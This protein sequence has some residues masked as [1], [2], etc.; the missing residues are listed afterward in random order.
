M[1]IKLLIAALAFALFSCSS[2]KM[3]LPK[4]K[5]VAEACLNAIAKEDY[6]KVKGEYYSDA[7]GAASADELDSKFKKLKDVMGEMQSFE[8]TDSAVN[9]NSGEEPNVILTYT[10]KH[11]KVTTTEKFVII[12]EGSKYKIMMHDIRN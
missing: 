7:L 2:E 10:V 11:S 6:A 12:I 8:L 3:E 5:E 1:K 9:N 4:A